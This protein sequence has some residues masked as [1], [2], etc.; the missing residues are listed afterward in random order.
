MRVE[1]NRANAVVETGNG[2]ISPTRK[3]FT[4]V[5]MDEKFVRSMSFSLSNLA[6]TLVHNANL[7]AH[8]TTSVVGGEGRFERYV[9]TTGISPSDAEE[10]RTLAENK[11]AE[12]LS[13]LDDW[14][15]EREQLFRKERDNASKLTD[16][17]N[18]GCGL[19][20]YYFEE[21]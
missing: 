18:A 14:V 12:L 19:G 10:F 1:L 16:R 20:V 3:H 15:G 9:W 17:S 8:E 13:E 4:P 21:S 11:A 2:L 6:A 5:D 7:P